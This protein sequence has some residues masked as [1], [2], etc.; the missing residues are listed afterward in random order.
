MTEK[1]T[2]GIEAFREAF[3]NLP[4]AGDPGGGAWLTAIR[5]AA[6]EDFTRRGIPG[7]R[8][9]EWKYT[10]LSRLK[11]HPY[12]ILPDRECSCSDETFAALEVPELESFRIVFVNG[13]LSEQ[14]SDLPAVDSGIE[15]M[16]MA[17]AIEN[18]P[19]AIE[20]LFGKEGPFDPQVFSQLNTALF[21]SGVYIHVK[22]GARVEQPVYLLYLNMHPGGPFMSHPRNILHLEEGSALDVVEDY[23][24]PTD[25][26]YF[27]N[28]VTE[29]LS[30]RDSGLRHYK[31]VRE[32]SDSCHV[33]NLRIRQ[34][35]GSFFSSHVYCL[36]G[37]IVRNDITALLD[38]ERIECSLNGLTVGSGRQHIDNHT[39]IVHARPNCN[40]WE[41]YK[42]VLADQAHGVFNGKIFVAQDAQ[43]TDA[44]QTNQSLL[45]S[46]TAVME[47]KPELE[48]Y[49]D[50]VK[51]THGATVGQ[52]DEEGM[53]YLRSRGLPQKTARDLLV[54]AFANDLVSATGI[55]ALK[56]TIESTLF[57]K[58][59]AICPPSAS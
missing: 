52:L 47:S 24:G 6:M 59:P 15:I 30:G 36:N 19:A 29:I 42:A 33:S 55:P 2:D 14:L 31:L 13:V 37:G 11:K 25:A 48:I 8:E 44:K 28:P 32:G 39:R 23:F 17:R 43:K 4:L 1:S 51:C 7:T 27:C 46:D 12:R 53:F 57:D 10:D 22:K 5:R 49:A 45:L 3:D 58:L 18:K 21:T 26:A 38:G 40:S 50:D 41:L 34:E 56:S 54:F 20:I 9:E 35:E 16:D